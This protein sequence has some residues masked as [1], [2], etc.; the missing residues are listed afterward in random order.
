MNK[1]RKKKKEKEKRLSFDSGF[2]IVLFVEVENFKQ[3]HENVECNK[4]R[5]EEK[6]EISWWPASSQV[7]P[8]L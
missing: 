2:G 3:Q 5:A 7:K 6:R 8:G 1:I 4:H